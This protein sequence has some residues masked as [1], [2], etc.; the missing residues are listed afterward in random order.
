[1]EGKLERWVSDEGKKV[2]GES[3]GKEEKADR[4]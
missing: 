1:M 2:K 3:V 4:K